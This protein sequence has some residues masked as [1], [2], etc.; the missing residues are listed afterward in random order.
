MENGNNQELVAESLKKLG[1]KLG[2]FMKNYL[3]RSASTVSVDSD[4][5]VADVQVTPVQ[6]PYDNAPRFPV[7]MIS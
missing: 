7:T 6:S 3:A 1:L 5:V 4:L 2:V